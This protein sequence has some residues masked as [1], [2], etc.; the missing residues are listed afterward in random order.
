MRSLSLQIPPAASTAYT[1]ILILETP[2]PHIT[3]PITATTSTATALSSTVVSATPT[4]KG[5]QVIGW[6][7]NL[8]LL[9]QM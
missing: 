1:T 5:E 4:T 8:D 7:L 6:L 3:A 2:S 9:S